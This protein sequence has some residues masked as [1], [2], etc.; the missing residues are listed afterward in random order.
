VKRLLNTLFV[1]TPGAYLAKD[2][3]SVLVKVNDETRL[4]VPAVNLS[5]VVCFGQATCSTYL[6]GFCAE[7]GITVTYLTEHGRFLARVEGG[8]SGNV[9]LRKGQYRCAGDAALVLPIARGFVTGKIANSRSVLQRALR[10][11]PGGDGAGRMEAVVRGLERQLEA[12]QAARS[13]EELRGLEG[14]ASRQY[15]GVFDHLIT[16]QKDAFVFRDRNRRPP[17]DKVNALLS[18]VYTLMVHDA[19]S[20][21]ETVG[22]D[23][24]AGFLH[25]D[26]PGRPSLAL[27]LMEEFRSVLGDRLVLSLINLRQVQGRG[28]RES[29]TDGVLMSDETRKEVLVAYQTRKQEEVDHPFLGEKVAIGLLLYA[30]A[31][32]LARHVRGDLDGYPPFFWR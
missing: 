26:R 12:A 1:T 8:V 10:D 31:L 20:A 7:S 29:E 24:Q 19:R 13:V 30:Q 23:P 25:Q 28:F 6:L 22:L 15:F 18:F 4:R 11:H 3:E 5:G 16:G 32:L 21:L 14:E 9:L 2:G 27:D 17:L